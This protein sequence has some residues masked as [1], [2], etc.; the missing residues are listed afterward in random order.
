VLDVL[1]DETAVAL[2]FTGT[3]RLGDASPM[4]LAGT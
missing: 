4:L 2:A 1:S 3:T